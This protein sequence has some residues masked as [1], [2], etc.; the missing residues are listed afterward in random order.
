MGFSPRPEFYHDTIS[1][2]QVSS[3]NLTPYVWNTRIRSRHTDILKGRREVSPKF[4]KLLVPLR[5]F[6]ISINTTVPPN[7]P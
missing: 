7:H 4:L 1:T 5:T 2:N 3:P 6:V